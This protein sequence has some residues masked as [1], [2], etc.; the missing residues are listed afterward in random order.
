MMTKC[1]MCDKGALIEGKVEEEMF[2]ISLGK[3]DAEM[4]DKP[5]EP[6]L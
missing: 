3:Y 2:G 6:S 1:P 4:C 5:L